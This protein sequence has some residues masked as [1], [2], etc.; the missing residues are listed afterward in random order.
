M[1]PRG[2]ETGVFRELLGKMAVS[3]G[4]SSPTPGARRAVRNEMRRTSG[5]P[6]GA[7]WEWTAT[8]V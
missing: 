5:A 3:P 2:A 7:L 8:F 1:R 6:T 4:K